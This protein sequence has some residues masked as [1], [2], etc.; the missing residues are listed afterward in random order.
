MWHAQ[1][2]NQRPRSAVEVSAS[3]KITVPA[4]MT[5]YFE[6][7]IASDGSSGEIVSP[8]Q[9][10][11]TTCTIIS[12]WMATSTVA[13]FQPM[14]ECGAFAPFGTCPSGPAGRTVSERLLGRWAFGSQLMR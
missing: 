12:S 7:S 4:L 8:V 14:R 6:V 10:H 5:P 3:R 2:Q 1:P 11:W 13:R 9:S